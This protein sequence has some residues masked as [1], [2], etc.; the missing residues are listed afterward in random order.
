MSS[1][2]S[3]LFAEDPCIYA[4]IFLLK[5]D[6][7]VEDN[8]SMSKVPEEMKDASKYRQNKPKFFSAPEYWFKKNKNL[9]VMN[10]KLEDQLGMSQDHF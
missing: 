6:L 9:S 5:K 7:K 10:F 1:K 2:S 8:K 3:G 4:P